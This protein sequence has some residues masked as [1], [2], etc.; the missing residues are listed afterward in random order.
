MAVMDCIG[1]VAGH[2]Y[3]LH[4]LPHRFVHA[5]LARHASL[6]RLVTKI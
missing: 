4:I 5:A 3:L 2:L 6:K 1:D